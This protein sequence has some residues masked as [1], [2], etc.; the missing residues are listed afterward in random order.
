MGLFKDCGC[1]CNGKKQEQ[2]FTI[3][4]MSALVFFIVA[5][6][7]T[8]RLMRRIFGS[9]VSGPNGCPTTTGLI[10]HTIVFM[11]ITWG[12]MN[13]KRESYAPYEPTEVQAPVMQVGPRPPMAKM[14]AGPSP[15]MAKMPVGPSP[16]MVDMPS[17]EPGMAEKAY[18]MMDSGSMF[19]SMDINADMDAPAMLK[20]PSTTGGATTCACSDGRKVVI[21]P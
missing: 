15:P 14:P 12:M 10:L 19:A 13:I 20:K 7:D 21:T 2:K 1:G 4:L 18:P 17:P 16:P 8:F 9:W 5:N 6:P 11:L 3:S